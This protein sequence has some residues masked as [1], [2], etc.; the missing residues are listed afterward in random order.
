MQIFVGADHQG[1]QL[2]SRLVTLLKRHGYEV[3]DEG[4]EKLNPG[5]DFPVFAAK[6]AGEVLA[7]ND[8]DPRG[9]LV[10]GSGQGM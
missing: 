7:S 3:A 9:I 8:Q 10:C 6:V 2:K 5:D 1:F 4:E